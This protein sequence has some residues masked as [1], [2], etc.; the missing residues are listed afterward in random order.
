MKQAMDNQRQNDDEKYD[1][2][3]NPVKAMNDR[4]NEPATKRISDLR[5]AVP[6]KQ[7]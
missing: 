6:K 5:H 7:N 2:F 4:L 3:V 1:E